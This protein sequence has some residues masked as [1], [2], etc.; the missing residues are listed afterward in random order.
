M[1]KPEQVTKNDWELLVEKYPKELD[2]IVE[3]IK[4]HYPVQYLIGNV[5]FYGYPIEVTE[6][7]LIPRFETEYL[8]EKVLKRIENLECPN[9]LDIGTG[10]GCISIALAKNK[11]GN[12]TAWDISDKALE[13]AQNNAKKNEVSI[14]FEKVDILHDEKYFPY[15]IIISN[16]P[17]IAEDETIASEVAYEPSIALYADNKGLEFYQ[18]ILE[19]VSQK[20]NHTL[21]LIAFEIGYLQ[22]QAL[23]DLANDYF[24]EATVEI[25]KDLSGKDRY[26]FITFFE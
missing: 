1:K 26:C 19:K 23:I 10:S 12:Y 6:D 16:P 17:Y 4:E 15:D 13:V 5:S 21:K 14:S 22:G 20:S 11:E 18:K 2:K 24:P 9:I 25:E 8:V 3:R 7:V